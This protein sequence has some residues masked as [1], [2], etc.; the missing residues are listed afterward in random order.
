MKLKNLLNEIHYGKEVVSQQNIKSEIK[1][2]INEDF[3]VYMVSERV[4]SILNECDAS[5]NYIKKLVRA[6]KDYADFEK[7]LIEGVSVSQIY[8]TMKSDSITKNINEAIQE[9]TQNRVTMRDANKEALGHAIATLKLGIEKIVEETNAKQFSL[10]ESNEVINMY[11][12]KAYKLLE[13][14]TKKDKK[15]KD[16]EEKKNKD[17]KPN[18]EFVEQPNKNPTDKPT[19]PAPKQNQEKETGNTLSDFLKKKEVQLGQGASEQ[20]PRNQNREPNNELV[21]YK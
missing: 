17:E 3:D 18:K 4:F 5:K 15:K 20:A 6:A 10:N 16:K 11:V 7:K 14:S 19:F 21:D 2:F 8:G 1:K 13:E 9:I 12:N